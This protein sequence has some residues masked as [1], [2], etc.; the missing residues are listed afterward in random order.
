MPSTART[1]ATADTTAAT[2]EAI[3]IMA[4]E[5]R[6]ADARIYSLPQIHGT[7]LKI[8]GTQFSSVK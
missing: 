1:I 3:M 8:S 4:A 6:I 7:F 5:E 2:A